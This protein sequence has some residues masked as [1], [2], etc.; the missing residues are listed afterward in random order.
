MAARGD[1]LFIASRTTR[2]A[3]RGPSAADRGLSEPSS[4]VIEGKRYPIERPAAERPGFLNIDWRSGFADPQ[5]L[6]VRRAARATADNE[7]IGSSPADDS[8]MPSARRC[9]KRAARPG[10]SESGWSR[11]AHWEPEAPEKDRTA[12]STGCFTHVR[13]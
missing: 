7:A 1:R 8:S 13:S 11:A 4:P 9:G 12:E 10:G 5:S 3:A 2:A 6:I